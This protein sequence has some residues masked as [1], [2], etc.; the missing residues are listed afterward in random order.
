MVLWL[1]IIFFVS[2]VGFLLE[3]IV[4]ATIFTAMV[5]IG[6][7]DIIVNLTLYMGLFIILSV[8]FTAFLR[9]NPEKIQ[10][11]EKWCYSNFKIRREL[12]FFISPASTVMIDK[13]DTYGKY[14][15][16]ISLLIAM[17]KSFYN[18]LLYALESI[19]YFTA[20]DIVQHFFYAG[21]DRE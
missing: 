10:S 14:K 20:V 9:A 17:S 4:G 8:Y 2:L 1:L 16:F 19:Q 15:V 13:E 7:H 18:L 12:I 11:W 3:P 5:F 21:I 6:I